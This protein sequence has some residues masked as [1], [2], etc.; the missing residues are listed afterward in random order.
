MNE[1][2]LANATNYTEWKK[3]AE[4]IDRESGTFSWREEEDSDLFHSQLLKE[5]IQMM[6]ECRESKKGLET[7]FSK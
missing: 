5:H 7:L 3:I 2:D 6:R 4:Q 1:Q